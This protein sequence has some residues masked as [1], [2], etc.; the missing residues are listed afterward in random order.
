MGPFVHEYMR[1]YHPVSY[2]CVRLG[3]GR[4]T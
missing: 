4:L 1:G 2:K 3:K